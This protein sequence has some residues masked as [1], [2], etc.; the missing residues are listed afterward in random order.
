MILLGSEVCPMFPEVSKKRGP[1]VGPVIP[2]PKSP[3]PSAPREALAAP[4]SPPAPVRSPSSPQP[5]PDAAIE[6]RGLAPTPPA[7]E[8]APPALPASTSGAEPRKRPRRQAPSAS[9]IGTD[10]APA[11]T[12]KAAGQQTTTGPQGVEITAVDVLLRAASSVISTCDDPLQVES[13]IPPAALPRRFPGEPT[14]ADLHWPPQPRGTGEAWPPEARLELNE[15]PPGRFPLAYAWPMLMDGKNWTWKHDGI[16]S[17][18]KPAEAIVVAAKAALNRGAASDPVVLV[19]PDTLGE[20]GQQ[21]LIDAGRACQVNLHLLP[22]S[23]AAAMTW[24]RKF[25]SEIAPDGAAAGAA[26]GTLLVM[27]FGLDLWEVSVI[28]IVSVRDGARVRCV[29]SR[30]RRAFH[31]VPSYGIELMH[32]LAIRSL[33]MSYQQVNAARVWELVWCTPWMKPALAT[34]GDHA[35]PFTPVVN[36]ARH[37]R[38]SEFLKQQCR[39]ATQRIFRTTEPV[40]GLMRQFLPKLPQFTELRDWFE[41]R[42]KESP[43][44]GHL[45]AVL[46]GPM[47]GI[48]F[49]KETVGAVHLA[50]VWPKPIRVLME[51][52]ELPRGFMT[53]GAKAHAARLAQKSAAASAPDSHAT[54]TEALAATSAISVSPPAEDL[55]ARD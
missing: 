46:T 6:R 30:R 12:A 29:P 53:A 38:S 4:A 40:P 20:A 24:C 45:G 8:A 39:Q 13:P 25:E 35:E 36:L 10:A 47:A 26:L 21:E 54:S 19:T 15:A 34:L 41:A 1:A 42:R 52:A 11:T 2:A 28:D 3:T 33:E 16:V 50:K 14:R 51:G 31:A 48:P 43:R 9:S 32:R 22:R 5:V 55:P 17:V 23:L 27:H 37:A 18:V 49:D 7:R 44:D